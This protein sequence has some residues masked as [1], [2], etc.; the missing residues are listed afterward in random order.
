MEL[1]EAVDRF[2]VAVA[3][4][5]GGEVGEQGFGPPVQGAPEAFDFTTDRAGRQYSQETFGC[6]AGIRWRVGVDQ[7]AHV[8]GDLPGDLDFDML[9]VGAECGV[10]AC[11][12]A[13]G[14]VLTPGAQDHAEPVQRI[15]LSA[16]VGECLVREAAARR[17]RRRSR[18]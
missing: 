18:V 12:L 5:V 16:A 1:D 8:V 7:V 2:S 4:A 13:V 6:P 10:Q 14:E 3:G 9:L 17:R 11:V 15:A